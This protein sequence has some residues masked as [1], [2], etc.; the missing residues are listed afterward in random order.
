MTNPSEI[1]SLVKILAQEPGPEAAAPEDRAAALQN[2][3]DLGE[4]A[5]P[6]LLDA[7]NT[8]YVAYLTRAFSFLGEPAIAP[9]IE[10]LGHDDAQARANAAYI[11]GK[12][13][14]EAAFQPLLRRLDDASELVRKEAVNALAFYRDKRMVPKL[15]P[16][17][18]DQSA[19]VRSA[20][21]VTLGLQGDIR[22]VEPLNDVFL[23]DEDEKVRRVAQEAIRRLGA[24]S[25]QESIEELDPDIQARMAEALHKSSQPATDTEKLFHTFG[26]PRYELLL[27]TL[28]STDHTV[29]RRAVRELIRM[30]EKVVEPLIAAAATNPLPQVRAHIAFALGELRDKRAVPILERLTKDDAEDVSYAATQ[31][32]H[33]LTE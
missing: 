14:P 23:R 17:L 30:G 9:L 33:K 29:Q 21:A 32:L 25:Q 24:R 28:E 10:K 5:L 15:L 31:A 3:W 19:D 16:L 26:I 22:A 8:P 2:V 7:L 1:Q 18:E 20:V 6:A 27:A 12:M 13:S 11:L 4:A